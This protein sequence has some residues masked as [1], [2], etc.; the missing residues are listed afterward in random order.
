VTRWLLVNAYHDGL[1]RVSGSFRLVM[2]LM[3]LD[4]LIGSS[5]GSGWETLRGRCDEHN[6]KFSLSSKPRFN[7]PV[8]ERRDS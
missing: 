3:A 7:Q 2:V 5:C 6:S 8:G 4:N 1:S